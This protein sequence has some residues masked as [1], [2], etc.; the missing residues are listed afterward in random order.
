M[1]ANLI[2]MNILV[3]SSGSMESIASDMVGGLNQ[4]VDEN[5]ELD[6]LVTY[7]IFSNAYQPLFA[8]KP[9]KETERFQ[10]RPSGCTAL[11]ESAHKMID[12]VGA[13]LAAKSEGER[14]EKVMFVIVTD[15]EENASAPEYTLEGLKAKIK[16]QTEVYNWV[17]LYLGADQDA[18]SV[19]ASYGID[20]SKAVAYAR[21]SSRKTGDVLA[22]KMRMMNEYRAAELQNIKFDDKDRADLG[23]PKNQNES[24]QKGTE[25]DDDT[26]SSQDRTPTQPLKFLRRFVAG[27]FRKR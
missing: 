21:A 26:P 7:S 23:E 6:V 24:S 19:A 14:P 22:E 18:I 20:A 4:L 25:N 17:F 15:G 2:S 3:D 11:I 9:I 5:R 12:E 27:L 13:R 16:K 1:K 8:D 10:L